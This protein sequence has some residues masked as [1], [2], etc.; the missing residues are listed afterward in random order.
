MTDQDNRIT[1]NYYAHIVGVNGQ[2]IFRDEAD[3]QFCL[4]LFSKKFGNNESFEMLA[5]CLAP[6]HVNLLIAQKT[7]ITTDKIISEIIFSYNAYYY[8][9]YAVEGIL[10]EENCE[11]VDV[12]SDNML[13]ISRNI[14]V[15][16]NE[17][18]D[19][20]YSSIR[21]YLYDDVPEWLNKQHI[22]KLYGSAV[23]YLAY[24]EKPIV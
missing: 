11:I 10:N 4:L 5:Y 21:A 1:S 12:K 7:N 14:H 16:P 20:P 15:K 19:C 2:Q 13:E 23:E 18:L 6:E 3:Y 8:E 22:A 9:K 24:L 17:W